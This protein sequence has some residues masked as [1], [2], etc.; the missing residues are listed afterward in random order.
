M[1]RMKTNNYSTRRR[2]TSTSVPNYLFVCHCKHNHTR[3]VLYSPKQGRELEEDVDFNLYYIDLYA[4]CDDDE[5]Q[6]HD[7]GSVPSSF[8][9]KVFLIKC[10]VLGIVNDDDYTQD[11]EYDTRNRCRDTAHS[12]LSHVYLLLKR[13]G[14]IIL[15][16]PIEMGAND[17]WQMNENYKV[18][19]HD[20]YGSIDRFMNYHGTHG[21]HLISK[22][23]HSY[24]SFNNIEVLYYDSIQER[25][26]DAAETLYLVLKKK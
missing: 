10:P 20:C 24:Q 25:I 13:H 1:S 14:E 17:R 2:S 8:F 16:L 26:E 9:D 23:N 18:T 6:F 4:H 11:E 19:L 7:W 5:R 3:Q 12:I 21:N 15:Q 22:Y